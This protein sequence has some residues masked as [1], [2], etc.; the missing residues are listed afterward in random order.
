MFLGLLGN[1]ISIVQSKMCVHM[2]GVPV[3]F[4]KKHWHGDDGQ[5]VLFVVAAAGWWY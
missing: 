4:L 5:G 2:R 3:D 1:G